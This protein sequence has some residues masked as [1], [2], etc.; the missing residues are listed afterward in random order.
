MSRIYQKIWPFALLA[1]TSLVIGCAFPMGTR[2]VDVT[3]DPKFQ[4][5]YSQ[6]QNYRLKT[7]GYLMEWRTGTADPKRVL[8]SASVA[9]QKPDPQNPTR[10]SWTQLAK[11]PAGST[12]RIERLQYSYFN[13]FP[14]FPPGGSVILCAFGTLKTPSAQWQD[15]VAPDGP[16]LDAHDHGGVDVFLPDTEFVE[17]VQCRPYPREP[18]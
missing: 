5:G 16:K 7:D 15:V 3:N 9:A 1:T 8:L 12:I 13:Y 11:I 2:T 10:S 17:K 18:F 14:P 4:V 6:G